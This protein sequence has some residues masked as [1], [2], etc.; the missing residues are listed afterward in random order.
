MIV[1]MLVVT[2]RAHCPSVD[3]G[4]ALTQISGRPFPSTLG[5]CALVGG[6]RSLKGSRY[7]GA[8]EA[9]ETV[10]RVNRLPHPRHFA[11]VG[12]RTDIY[13]VNTLSKFDRLATRLQW[14]NGVDPQS[15]SCDHALESCEH[16]MSGPKMIVFEGA[17]FDDFWRVGN[18][19]RTR[20]PRNQRAVEAAKKSIKNFPQNRT[21][22]FPGAHPVAHQSHALHFFEHNLP[23]V[24]YK[25]DQTI[26]RRINDRVAAWGYSS[27]PSGGLKA[28]L[29]FANLCDSLTLFGFGGDNRSLDG[30]AEIGHSFHVEHAFY[31]RLQRLGASSHHHH[32]RRRSTSAAAAN[33][34]S[35]SSS[36]SS[37]QE[38]DDDIRH[39]FPTFF[40]KHPTDLL[41]RYFQ[42]FADRITCLARHGRI[43]VVH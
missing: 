17:P 2:T 35:S 19:P 12:T 33:S 11:D 32:H 26:D 1:A 39:F 4:D 20:P 14:E 30:H 16:F 24:P 34:S 3:V 9:L 43:S 29:T 37:E 13:F 22:P 5:Q 23:V 15:R 42:L 21:V 6:S 40:K 41:H 7:G 28:F 31:A 8:I 25:F 18:V 27:K 38:K 10:I 36:S